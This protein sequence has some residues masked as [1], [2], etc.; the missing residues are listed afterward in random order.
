MALMEYATDQHAL[1][2][3]RS[4][5]YQVT[6]RPS[7]AVAAMFFREAR[8][9]GLTPR[10]LYG[11]VKAAHN[12]PVTPSQDVPVWMPLAMQIAG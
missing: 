6:G 12:D 11:L 8:Q 5:G 10:E 9:W 7:D 3:L 1:D 4:L 2:W